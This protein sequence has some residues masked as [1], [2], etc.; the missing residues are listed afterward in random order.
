M[1]LK[2]T[3]ELKE[4]STDTRGGAKESTWGCVDRRWDTGYQAKLHVDTGPD[5]LQPS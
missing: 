3:L 4:V 1:L 2:R 5:D